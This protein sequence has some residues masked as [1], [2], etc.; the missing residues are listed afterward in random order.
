MQYLFVGQKCLIGKWFIDVYLINN[1][2]L[3]VKKIKAKRESD[4]A[5]RTNELIK[6]TY[7]TPHTN[8]H[9]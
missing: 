5:K 4:I 8:Y 6:L 7:Y 9:G 2:V 3:I 1:C